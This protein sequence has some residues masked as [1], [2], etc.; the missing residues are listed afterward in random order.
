MGGKRVCI[1]GKCPPLQGG[2]STHTFWAARCLALAGWEVHLVSNALEAS[3]CYRHVM[4]PDD[5]RFLSS[6]TPQTL[7]I[8]YTTPVPDGSFIPFTRP[9]ASQLLGLV[10]ALSSKGSFDAFIG[11][12]LEPY[13]LVASLL[14][15]LSGAPVFIRHAGSDIGRLICEPDLRA[16]AQ[17]ALA[18]PAQVLTT[19]FHRETFV[20]LGVPP[21][22]QIHFGSPRLPDYHTTALQPFPLEDYRREF[23]AWFNRAVGEASFADTLLHSESVPADCPR[24]GIYGKVGRTKGSFALLRALSDERLLG[25]PFQFFTVACGHSRALKA[26]FQE[27][28]TCEPLAHRTVCLPPLPPWRISGFLRSL[29]IVFFL[30]NRF[31]IQFHSPI[32][33]REILASGACLICS[34][35]IADKL[36][37]RQNLVPSRNIIIVEDPECHEELVRVIRDILSDPT[38][39]KSVGKH[40]QFLSQFVEESFPEQHPMQRLLESNGT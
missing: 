36:P 34:R 39:A 29:N 30:E 9:F 28:A 6:V 2:T 37:Y 40:G 21:E 33:V 27:L 11:W 24:I 3:A 22:R 19:P 13:G 26:Y 8:H 12:Y 25:I 32:L 4:L 23:A 35:E 31:P 15:R 18:E 14:G 17:L 7:H 10:H 1:V 5:E 16:A 38:H 20:S